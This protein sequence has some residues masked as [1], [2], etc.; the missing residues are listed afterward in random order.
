MPRDLIHHRHAPHECGRAYAAF[1]D[2]DSALRHRSTIASCFSEGHAI[3]WSVEA[4]DE[5]DA[6]A[7]LPFFVAQRSPVTHVREVAIP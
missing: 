6:L 3:W 5:E 1:K 2:H 4:A 7:L